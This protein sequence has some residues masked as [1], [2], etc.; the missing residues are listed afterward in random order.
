MELLHTIR[1]HQLLGNG[2]FLFCKL[3]A[4][5]VLAILGGTGGAWRMQQELGKDPGKP[6]VETALKPLVYLVPYF[7]ILF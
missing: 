6:W 5:S 4:H 7:T 3:L 2:P 1:S